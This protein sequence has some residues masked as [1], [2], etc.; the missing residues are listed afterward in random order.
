[1]ATFEHKRYPQL[2]LHD[3]KAVWAQFDGGRLTT[4]DDELA[5]RLRAATDP[6]LVEVVEETPPPAAKPY[7]GVE[8]SADTIL[9][10]VGDDPVK[11]REALAAEQAAEKPR[12][13][14]VPKLDKLAGN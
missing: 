10:W 11:A 7:P 2:Q 9:A 14:L 4:T 13:T 6:D 12:G 5:E 8:A 1:M 3:G